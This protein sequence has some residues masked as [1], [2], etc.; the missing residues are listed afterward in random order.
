MGIGWN[1]NH[2]ATSKTGGLEQYEA[3]QAAALKQAR[4]DIA[5][6]VLRNTEVVSTFWTAFRD[7]EADV[8]LWI[9]RPPGSGK[10]YS[11]PW[12]TDDGK[13]GGPTPKFFL[14]FSNPKTQDWWLQKYIAPA[15]DQPDIDGIYT[16]CSCGNARQY[17][18]T[19]AEW[20]GRQK[21]FDAAL[22]LAA[23]KGKWFSA[24]AGAAVTRAPSS[25]ANC[26]A[27]MRGLLVLAVNLKILHNAPFF[28]NGAKSGFEMCFG[29]STLGAG[30]KTRLESRIKEFTPHC[31]C[32]VRTKAIQCSLKAVTPC[33]SVNGVKIKQ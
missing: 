10:P 23:S 9:Q 32:R 1:L 24:W 21:A 12:G 16:D 31:V 28:Q 4:P 6:M 5:V 33:R 29:L 20:A 27:V 17:R 13:S 19:V 7:A 15:L 26:A 25:A 8:D 18:P 22:V 30:A 11:E 3:Q 14:N 2:L